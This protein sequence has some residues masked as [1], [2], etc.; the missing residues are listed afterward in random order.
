MKHFLDYSV[1]YTKAST[2]E[3]KHRNQQ[4]DRPSQH[5][6]ICNTP[7]IG[8]HVPFLAKFPSF[9]TWFARLPRHQ[10]FDKYRAGSPG[11]FNGLYYFPDGK[12]AEEFKV[13]DVVAANGTLNLT[14]S[15]LKTDKY[16][17][18]QHIGQRV[19]DNLEI[20]RHG[21]IDLKMEG[22]DF[23]SSEQL[24]N[25]SKFVNQLIDVN[26]ILIIFQFK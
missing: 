2:D 1:P 26:F 10:Y 4:Y 13:P 21:Y 23:R 24:L 25:L 6:S 3:L 17:L 5:I 15:F 11:V 12:N 19:V 8:H 7:R 22:A 14:Q 9:S 18:L 20:Q 16:K